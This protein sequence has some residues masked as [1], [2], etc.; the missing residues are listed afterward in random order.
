MFSRPPWRARVS[1][2]QQLS[3]TT[4]NSRPQIAQI[5]QTKVTQNR[6]LAGVL[7]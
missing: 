1:F 6:S 4:N 7:P 2:R 5:S 3:A